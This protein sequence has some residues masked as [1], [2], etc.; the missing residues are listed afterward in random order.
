MGG[1]HAHADVDHARRAWCGCIGLGMAAPYL[2]MV[3][4]PGL[5][6]FLP[7]PG[8]WVANIEKGVAFFLMGTCIYL[9]NI[10]PEDRLIAALILLWIT[11]LAAW[12]LGRASRANGRGSAM[13]LRALALALVLAAFVWAM[14]PRA[15]TAWTEFRAADFAQRLGR[16]TVFV[17]FTAD[18]CPSCKVLNQAVLTQ[19]NIASWR[20]RYDL[21]LV[22]VDLSQ[23]NPEGEA[24]LQALGSRS[25]PALA[26]FPAK[27]P[28]RPIVLRDFYSSRDI[29]QALD[30]SLQR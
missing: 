8:P 28:E 21:T 20:E 13:L 30:K 25:I 4:S 29:R 5:V 10:L 9:L 16:E 27:S 2:I 18:W 14:R 22:R 26:V 12:L 17:E 6:R 7:K 19:D 24:L 1:R 3:A 15:A 11:A 23:P